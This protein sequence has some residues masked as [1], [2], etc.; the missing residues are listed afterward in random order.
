MSHFASK[1]LV[2][3][4]RNDDDD[5]DGNNMLS[6]SSFFFFSFLWLNVVCLDISDVII[7]TKLFIDFKIENHIF[8]QVLLFLRTY[9]D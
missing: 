9:R 6:I 1:F 4:I 7:I 8:Y 2:Q 5:D 3:M